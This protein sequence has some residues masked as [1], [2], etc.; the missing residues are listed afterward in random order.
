MMLTLSTFEKEV[1]AQSQLQPNAAS[2][3]HHKLFKILKDIDV[4]YS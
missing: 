4:N 3:I 1:A 2:K